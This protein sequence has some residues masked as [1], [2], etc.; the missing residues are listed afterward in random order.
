MVTGFWRGFSMIMIFEVVSLIGEDNSKVFKTS[1]G[2][3]IMF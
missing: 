1:G 3:A 2:E